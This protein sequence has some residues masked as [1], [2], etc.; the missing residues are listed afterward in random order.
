LSDFERKILAGMGKA[1]IIS[2]MH[3]RRIF[4]VKRKWLPFLASG[5]VAVAFS[6]AEDIPFGW[7]QNSE[8]ELFLVAQKALEDGFYD[9]AIRYIEQLQE[10]YPQTD[11]R[12][13]SNILLGQCYFFKSQYLKAYTIFHDLM[14]YSEFKDA[15]LFWLGETYL[16]GSD[17]KQ[18]EEQYRQ[19][20]KVYPDS[21]YAPQAYYSLG[22]VYF[23]QDQFKEAQKV[24]EE[25]TRKFPDHQ[26]TEDARFKLGETMYNL[27]EYENT[28]RHFD[29]Y[30]YDYPKSTR[31]GEA[32]FYIGESC[33]S[34]EDFLRAVTYYAKTAEI[35]YDSKLILMAKVSLGWCY[36]RLGK[37]SLGQKH[38]D[39]AYAFS[40]QKGILTD[41]VLLG[42]ASLYSEMKEYERALAAYKDLLEKF[43]ASPRLPEAYLGRANI[44]YLMER[45]EKAIPSYREVIDRVALRPGHQELLEKAYFGLAWSHLKLGDMDASVKNFEIVKN[46]TANKIVKISALTQI[47]DAYQDVGQWERAI[48]VYDAILQDY[49]ESPY[50]DY[51]QYR[52]GIALLKMERIDAATLSFQ[53]L[54]A[55]FPGSKYLNDVQYYLA[56]AYFKKGNWVAA[57]DRIAEFIEG[58]LKED[59]FMAEAQY[60]LAITH[61]N[62]RD[63]SQALKVFEKILRDYPE[64]PSMIK[65]SKMIIAKCYYK[66]GN[67]SE[68]LE[69]FK[70]LVDIYPQSVVA[71]DALIWLG[72][73]FLESMELDNA[74]IYYTRFIQQFPGG[75]KVNLVYYELGQTYQ[76][77]GDWDEA[78]HAFQKVDPSGEKE[79]H[80][81]ARMAI[82]DIFSQEMDPAPALETYQNIVE[83]SPEFR[84]SAYVKM[85]DVHKGNKDYENAVEAYRN[86]LKAKEDFSGV[87]DAQ[88][89][90][91]I[92]D[93]YESGNKKDKAVEEYL[94]LPYL[95]A[96]EVPWLVKAYLRIGRIFEDAEE[97]DKAA[98]I[99]KKV[100]PYET[101]ELKFV[102]ERLDWIK[103]HVGEEAVK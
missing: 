54:Q 60:I 82:A 41:D 9:V 102:Q 32:Y 51:I 46:K 19:L 53:S 26:L 10:Q 56:V 94:K 42:R 59:A 76:A 8:Q 77:R 74:I 17:Y 23:E 36:L 55:N 70:N 83:T 30:V 6:L 79:L 22:W 44:Y 38:F 2:P 31:R 12:I 34:L 33:Y 3:S 100:L 50:T 64:D 98:T 37:L 73:H 67:V 15:T 58:R 40:R 90:F 28:I 93:A 84:R 48:E 97:W 61:F 89:Q 57:R 88:I 81:R 18:A 7:A 75:P 16:K 47:G 29:Q 43:P 72:D 87:K 91:F 92:G 103:E 35:A 27:K 63:Y 39:E 86:A 95:Y 101:D 24:L 66:M 11:K 4:P 99:Y 68:A 13:E 71:Q 80:A 96:R 65:N 1:V 20:I 52:Q 14:Q 5:I 69:R 21:I 78:V 49:P 85:A 45:Y 62:L 25:F